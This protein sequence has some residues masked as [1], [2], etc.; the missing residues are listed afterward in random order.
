MVL[1]F[2]DL[3]TKKDSH[4]SVLEKEMHNFKK[5]CIG[6]CM[7]TQVKQKLHEADVEADSD[8][9]SLPDQLVSPG[10]YEPAQLPTRKEHTAPGKPENK[11]H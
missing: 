7:D 11:E 5:F 8:I 10:E 9:G 2:H 3:A 1:I 6:Y 4:Y